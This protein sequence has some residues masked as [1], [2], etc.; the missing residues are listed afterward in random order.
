MSTYEIISD[1][2]QIQAEYEAMRANGESHRMAEMLALQQMPFGH[3]ENRLLM[4][5][6]ESGK[7]FSHQLNDWVSDA[8]D[9]RY[10]AERDKLNVRNIVD[11]E[12]PERPPMESIPIAEDIVDE[13]VELAIAIDPGKATKREQLREEIKDRLTP[14]YKKT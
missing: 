7:F 11:I 2:P 5:G 12:Q 9:V 14:D 10:I 4:E 1:N 8:S 3:D 6:N 13:E